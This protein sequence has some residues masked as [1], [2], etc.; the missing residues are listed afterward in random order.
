MKNFTMNMT[1][2]VAALTL[3][4]GT[5]SAQTVKAEIPFAFRVGGQIMQPGRVSRRSSY[6]LRRVCRSST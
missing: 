2:A 3:A 6:P 1:L 4:A 5:A